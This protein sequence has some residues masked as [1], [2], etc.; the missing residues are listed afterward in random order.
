MSHHLQT[1]NTAPWGHPTVQPLVEFRN[2]TKKFNRTI[3]LENFSLKIYHDEFFAFLGPSGCGK[4]TLMRMLA[5]LE[6]PTSGDILLDGELIN[7]IPAHKRPINMMFQ[8]YALFPHMT[9]WNNV[10]YGLRQESIALEEISERVSILLKLVKLDKLSNRKPDQLSGG[11]RQRVALARALAKKPKVLL[12]D[13]PLG[14]LDR[15]LR[16]ATQFELLGLQRNLKSSFLMVT[17]DQDE[18]M[19]MADRIAVMNKGNIEQ[20]GTPQQIYE[21]PESRFVAEF[22]GDINIFEGNIEMS[23]QQQVVISTKYGQIFVK[24]N[25]ISLASQYLIAAIRPEKI[26]LSR[27]EPINVENRVRCK[28]HEIGYVGDRTFIVLLCGCNSEVALK[29]TISNGSS[30]G[31]VSLR[32]GESLWAYWKSDDLITI[33]C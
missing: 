24:T 30:S 26:N 20:I 14:A 28:I 22:V 15:R 12:L 33:K 8:S 11:E 13:E 31:D 23:S 6:E 21:R 19:T 29:V 27:D 25:D 16:E 9:V 1:T 3:A 4:S 32:I 18:A 10:A 5:G 7:N 17:H 2:I